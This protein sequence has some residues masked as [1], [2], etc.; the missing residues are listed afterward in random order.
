[1]LIARRSFR[2]LIGAVLAAGLSSGC[3]VG[4]DPTPPSLVL[5]DAWHAELVDGLERGDDGPEAWWQS[6]D[7]PFLSEL[8]AIAEVR[9]LDLRIAASRIREARSLYGV[10]AADLFPTA[11]VEGKGL[12]TDSEE[13]SAKTAG[14]PA[15]ER[16]YSANMDLSWEP[17]I[18]GRV[19]RGMQSAE[20]TVMEAVEDRRDVLVAIR[21]EVAR[22]YLQARSYQ[23]QAKALA[24]DLAT[25][26][27]TLQLVE[28]RFE[29]GAA[30]ELDVAQ[31]SAQA[32][33]T[34]SQLPVLQ[35]SFVESVNRISVLI[36]E[37]AGPLQNRMGLTF[38]PAQPVPQTQDTIAVGIPADAIRHRPDI[39]AAERSVM[40]AAARIGVA[41]AA[42][43]PSLRFTGSGGFTSSGLDGLFSRN[44]LQGIFGI[45]FSWPIF[46]AGRLRNLIDVRSE[47]AEQAL[48]TYERTVLE[49]VAEVET[50]M[51]AYASSMESRRR[52]QETVVSYETAVGLAM[53]R[54]KAGVDDLQVLLTAE[55]GVQEARQQLA[56][57]EGRV[58]SNVVGIYKSLGGAWEIGDLSGRAANDETGDESVETQ[59]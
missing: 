22:S 48:L 7:D 18:W 3:M 50:S 53:Q 54:F 25:R 32:D 27:E 31:A 56:L 20:Y 49:A 1:M 11:T 58:A 39:R 57:T 8:I 10:A 59:G 45:E 15:P 51:V 35:S 43:Y 36:G 33:I 4:P 41:E 14:V 30:T 26:I 42:L 24:A 29:Q 2:P 9:N 23:G 5:P 16:F 40:A 6:F 21:A 19:R 37:S 38:D 44:N 17:D 34:A 46:T 55:R 28:A 52:L 12:W 13:G 47:Q